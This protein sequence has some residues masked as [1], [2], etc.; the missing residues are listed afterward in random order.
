MVT[1]AVEAM[2]VVGSHWGPKWS[3]HK[4]EENPT[5]S[6]NFRSSFHVFEGSWLISMPNLNG[7]IVLVTVKI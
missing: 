4:I 7:F 5:S 6:M 3:V 2:A 1:A